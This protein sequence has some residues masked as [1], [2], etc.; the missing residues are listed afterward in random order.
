[1][2]WLQ[3]FQ[4]GWPDSQMNRSQSDDTD[5]CNSVVDDTSHVDL[6]WRRMDLRRHDGHTVLRLPLRR[7]VRP[8]GGLRGQLH[9]LDR[10]GG[11]EQAEEFNI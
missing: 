11:I 5:D 1:M 2:S 6:C 3:S 9:L 4:S 8:Q 7:Q 10:G